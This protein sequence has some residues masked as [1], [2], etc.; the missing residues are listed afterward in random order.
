MARAVTVPTRTPADEL[1][2]LLDQS[3]RL[4][5]G[6][7]G[8]SPD[9]A[10]QLLTALDRIVILFPELEAAGVDLQPERG[11][12]QG[13]QGAVRRHRRSL[14]AALKPAGG[15]A[16]A[17]AQ[18]PTPPPTAN[19]WWQTDL[20]LAAE[21]RRKTLTWMAVTGGLILALALGYWLFNR[22]FPVDPLVA[23]LYRLRNEA[24]QALIE[25]ELAPALAAYETAAALSP[26]DPE[27]LAWLSALYDAA[28][29]DADAEAAQAQLRPLRP[30]FEVDSLLASAYLGLRWPDEAKIYIDQALA[31]NPS[32]VISLITAAD[33]SQARGEIQEAMTYLERADEAAGAQ[34]LFREQA[35]IRVR[36]AQLLQQPLLPT[37]AGE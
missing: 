18:Q 19:W 21:T 6:M 1:R 16:T 31:A 11:R 36:L 13:V 3:E 14:Q 25:G 33:I 24:Q 10:R 32:H 22:L 30:A 23:E 34:S 2:S 5:V 15:L 4:A 8:A 12:W 7:A 28:G 26:D 27:T 37:P 20:I 29:R 9:Q 17:R 35:V